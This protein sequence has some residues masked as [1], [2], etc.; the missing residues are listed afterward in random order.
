MPRSRRGSLTPKSLRKVAATI[1]EHG[2]E[3]VAVVMQGKLGTGDVVLEAGITAQV[4]NRD[5]ITGE[6][7]SSRDPGAS[8]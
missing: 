1:A 8:R 4:K 6:R 2:A 3:S 5:L 7:Q